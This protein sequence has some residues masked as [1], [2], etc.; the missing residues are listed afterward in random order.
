MEHGTRGKLPVICPTS[1]AT[2]LRQINA[3]G[4]SGG[5]REKLS[6]LSCPGRVAACSRRCEASS[7]MPRRRSGTYTPSVPA[8]GPPDQRCIAKALRSGE[9]AII[10]AA[11]RLQ[12]A[13]ACH[14]AR[15]KLMMLRVMP[16]SGQ[17]GMIRHGVN[18][19]SRSPSSLKDRTC[20]VPTHSG[21]QATSTLVVQV[22]SSV[23]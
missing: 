16:L 10:R 13:S 4:K 15:S 8:C 18:T 20:F 22:S 21:F 5:L 3:T 17:F 7:G 9:R 1:Q 2:C 11:G 19:S 6:S 23:V 14:L 12:P